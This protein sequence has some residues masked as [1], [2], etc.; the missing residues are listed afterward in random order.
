MGRNMGTASYL[1]SLSSVARRI[2]KRELG[3]QRG[4]QRG[5]T[6]PFR[7]QGIVGVKAHGTPIL[8]DKPGRMAVW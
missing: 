2:N 4:K 3:K 8:S 5:D 6:A 7:G 1:G